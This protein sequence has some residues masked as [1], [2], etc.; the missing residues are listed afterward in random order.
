MEG[1]K[2]KSVLIGRDASAELIRKINSRKTLEAQKREIL[3][4]IN[5]ITKAIDAQ[6][7]TVQEILRL[8]SQHKINSVLAG[9][10]CLSAYKDALKMKLPTI[11]TQ[12][13]DFL[14]PRPYKGKK[15]DIESILSDLGFSIDFNPDGSTYFTNGIFK[16]EFLNQKTAKAL[17]RQF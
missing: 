5:V 14:V 17:T 4:N 2:V 10:H 3:D 12:D 13:V 9:S 8:F 1:K 7:V 15:A 6:T 16:I 11:K